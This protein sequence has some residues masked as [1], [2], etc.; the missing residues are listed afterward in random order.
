[1]FQQNVA[2]QFCLKLVEGSCGHLLAK[3]PDQWV[4]CYLLMVDAW[5]DY[6]FHAV[7]VAD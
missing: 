4:A 3:I 5:Q 1:M 7:H 2:S 6:L